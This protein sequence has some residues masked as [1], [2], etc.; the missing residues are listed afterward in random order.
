MRFL[1]RW[2]CTGDA[3]RCTH[4]WIHLSIFIISKYDFT[5]R[6]VC[7][8]Y[9]LTCSMFCNVKIMLRKVFCVFN[10]YYFSTRCFC[11]L[12]TRW[13]GLLHPNSIHPQTPLH[14]A[15]Q[16]PFLIPPFQN[17]ILTAHYFQFR[18]RLE[19]LTNFVPQN[20]LVGA[21]D[22]R[23]LSIPKHAQQAVT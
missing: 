3:W 18:Y 7:N 4:V 15:T 20:T 14:A 17:Y 13:L 11:P 6:G 12:K 5:L 2:R 19:F 16:Q 9:I 23:V 10:Y 1:V 8:H 21:V 22:T